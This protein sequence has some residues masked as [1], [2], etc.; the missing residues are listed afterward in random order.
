MKKNKLVSLVIL[1][2]ILSA[3]SGAKSNEKLSDD[4]LYKEIAIMDSVMFDAFNAQDLNKLKATFSE[5]LE[6]YHDKGGLSDY[7]K[8]WKIL[9]P[10][11][12][13]IKQPA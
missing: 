3:F 5:D 7:K 11:L 8:K 10:C 1:L 2:F 13:E 4:K 12:N 9:K 6:F